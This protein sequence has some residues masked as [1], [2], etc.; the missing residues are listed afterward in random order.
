LESLLHICFVRQVF[1][2]PGSNMTQSYYLKIERQ[3]VK[4]LWLADTV[5]PVCNISYT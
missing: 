3:T 4:H 1:H 5:V 2:T